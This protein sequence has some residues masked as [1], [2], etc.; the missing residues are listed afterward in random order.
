M[1]FPHLAVASGPDT[2]G[3]AG[4]RRRAARLR[5]DF[6]G[7]AEPHAGGLA[8]EHGFLESR[9]LREARAICGGAHALRCKRVVRALAA[10]NCGV[11]RVVE[12]P[13]L[14]CRRWTAQANRWEN[15]TAVTSFFEGARSSTH[16]SVELTFAIRGGGGEVLKKEGDHRLPKSHEH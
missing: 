9:L 8:E 7:R 11:A 5:V 3:R 13:G 4:A 16:P 2:P 12:S 6:G 10:V 15:T 14:R 1:C